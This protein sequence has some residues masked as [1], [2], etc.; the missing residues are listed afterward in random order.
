MGQS[1]HE[2][3]APV[4][5][6]FALPLSATFGFGDRVRKKSGAAWQGQVVGWYCTK[7]TPEGYAVESESH[8]GSVQIYPVAAL[9]RVA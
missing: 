2:A 9:E 7:L 5:G 6:Q 4:A 1:S 8:P 3:N